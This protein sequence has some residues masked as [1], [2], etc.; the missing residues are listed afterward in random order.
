MFTL[1]SLGPLIRLTTLWISL[2][3]NRIRL[4]PT[5]KP[6]WFTQIF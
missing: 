4:I 6:V 2:S 1:T 5:R 3:S